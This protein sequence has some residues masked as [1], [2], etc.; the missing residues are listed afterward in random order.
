MAGAGIGEAAA[1]L[2]SVFPSA[3]GDFFECTD[4]EAGK[5]FMH[6]FVA[7]GAAVRYRAIHEQ[8]VED[9]VALDVAL[10]QNDQ[11]WVEALPEDVRS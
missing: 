5:A 2:R 9:I 7:A 6:R 4:D 10:K 1:Y 8:Q 11:E 3:Q